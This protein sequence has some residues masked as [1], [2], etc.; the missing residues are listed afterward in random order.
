MTAMN[1]IRQAITFISPAIMS[2]LHL[3]ATDKS[4]EDFMTTVTKQNLEY[5]KKNHIIRKD[6]FQLLMQL[7]DSG[8]I[9]Q[10]DDEW[11]TN[12]GEHSDKKQGKCLTFKEMTAQSFIFF[13]AG[14]WFFFYLLL[15]PHRPH[16]RSVCMNWQKHR[17][18]SVKYT[19]K[20]IQLYRNTTENLRT[21][22]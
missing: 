6:F 14:F 1:G 9:V 8:S 17:T 2:S 12:I 7:R 3:R 11:Q 15:K 20:S 18:F 21:M 13:L 5:R 10:N 22:R 4:V 16:S 19:K